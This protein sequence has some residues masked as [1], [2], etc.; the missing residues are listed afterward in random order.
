MTA[1]AGA[2]Y[3][4]GTVNVTAGSQSVTGVGTNWQNDVISI[5]IGDIFT[6]DT[7]TWYEVT[8]VNSDTS[9]TLDRAFEGS[10]FSGENYAIIRNTSGTILTRIAGQISV[11][12]NQKQLFLDELRQWLNSDEELSKI[13]D[14]HGISHQIKTIKEIQ[15]TCEN[16]ANTALNAAVETNTAIETALGLASDIL[17]HHTPALSVTFNDGIRIEHGYGMHDKLDISAAQDGSLL[18]DMPTKS[19]EFSRSSAAWNINKSGILEELE[20]NEP[21]IGSNGVWVHESYTNYI[22]NST[23][24]YTKPGT[25]ASLTQKSGGILFGSNCAEFVEDLTAGEHFVNL[26]NVSVPVGQEYNFS[27]Y[28]KA[29][30]NKGSRYFTLRTHSGNISQTQFTVD[31]NG[32]IA[33]SQGVVE[34]IGDGWYRCSIQ[35]T[36]TLETPPTGMRLQITDNAGNLSYTGNGVS[37]FIISG[38]QVTQKDALLPLIV[39]GDTAE[40]VAATSHSIPIKGNLPVKGHSFTISINAEFRDISSATTAHILS[41]G[42]DTDNAAILFRK[43]GDQLQFYFD[44][45]DGTDQRLTDATPEY[46]I[47]RHFYTLTFD[48]TTDTF[49]LYCDGVLLSQKVYPD[50]CWFDPEKTLSFDGRYNNQIKSLKILHYAASAEEVRSWG[51]PK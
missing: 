36:S 50:Y 3:R 43:V 1:S 32:V 4:V 10:T 7:K 41:F 31:S 30:A 16:A 38:A 34:N 35:L 20:L 15:N 6:L 26:E 18:I 47:G 23:A 19:V 12:F 45:S 14:S 2:W 37:S 27:I 13:T 17:P 29:N 28:I 40:T 48:G 39:T 21:A 33:S 9:I 42:S 25:R 51:A 49:T 5:A 44:K 22:K 8:A 11:Q 24:L 46:A